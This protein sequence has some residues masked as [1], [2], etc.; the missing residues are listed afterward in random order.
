MRV[1]N[2]KAAAAL[3]VDP[4]DHR[5]CTE[6]HSFGVGDKG[7]ATIDKRMVLRI[8]LVEADSILEPVTTLAS[9]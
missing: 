4:V 5:A 1:R 9:K 3:V 7:H 6:D 8:D 2:E